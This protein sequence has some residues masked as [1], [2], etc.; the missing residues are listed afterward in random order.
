MVVLFSVNDTVFPEKIIEWCEKNKIKTNCYSEHGEY[1]ITEYS[2]DLVE[3]WNY[4]KENFIFR[5]IISNPYYD[6]EEDDKEYHFGI[7]FK[8]ITISE[9]KEMIS[10]KNSEW[11]H[12]LCSLVREFGGEGDPKI[13]GYVNIT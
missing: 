4:K 8:E 3:Y 7:S 10:I 2:L 13:M 12:E 9:M 1:L 5:F 6:C 11:Y